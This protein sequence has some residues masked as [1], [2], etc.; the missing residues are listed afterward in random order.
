LHDRGRRAAAGRFLIDGVRLVEAALAAGAPVEQLLVTSAAA[1]PRLAAL[2]EMARSRGVPLVEVAPHVL[3]AVSEVESPQGVVA[4]V[5]HRAGTLEGPLGRGDLLLLVVDRVQDPGNL[6]TMIRTA[7]AAGATAVALT[8]GT[9]DPTNP[10]AARATMGSL[11]HLP[12]AE[13]EP[14]GLRGA[15]R[16]QGVRLLAADT[17]GTVSVRE[18]DYTR[19]VALAVG[20]EAEG[21]AP[22]WLEA[23]DQVVRIPLLGRADS[24][25]VAVAAAILLYEAS[26]PVYT[27]AQ[28]PPPAVRGR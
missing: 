15:L 6:G 23:A 25:N 17:A 27:E 28:S 5:R 8:P 13:M 22:A 14:E 20:N 3:E 24:L 1:A 19:P 4:V 26:A 21:L 7:D 11:F 10:K 16:A 12:V 9:V 2:S 18:A